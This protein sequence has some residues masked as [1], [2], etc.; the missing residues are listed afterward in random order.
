MLTRLFNGVITMKRKTDFNN[1]AFTLIELMI[2]LVILGLLAT[3]IMPRILNRPEQ[4]RRTKAK[5][6]IRNIESALALFKTDTGRFPTTSEGLGVLVTNPGIKGY[7][8]DAYLDKVPTDPWGNKYV[9]ICP[10]V[11]G[12]DY[13]LKSYGKDGE[14]GGTGFDA[15][16]ESWNIDE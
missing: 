7:D 5:I 12:R 2:V 4:A 15:D 6:E 16:I 8:P 14:N 3:T 1:K 13:D 9:Y 11:Q 10:G